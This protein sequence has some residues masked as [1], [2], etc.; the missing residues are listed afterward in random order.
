MRKNTMLQATFGVVMSTVDTCTDL[1]VLADAASTVPVRREP[2][3][4]PLECATDA[5]VNLDTPHS[6]NS[7]G[8]ESDT[9]YNSAE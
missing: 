8:Y 1:E 9:I 5:S 7:M 6:L 4:L 3:G 2:P